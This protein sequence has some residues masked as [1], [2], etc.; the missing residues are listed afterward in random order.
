MDCHATLSTIVFPSPKSSSSN[1]FFHFVD[2]YFA[3]MTVMRNAWLISVFSIEV[4]VHRP[5][6]QFSMY[7]DSGSEQDGAVVGLS[8]DDRGFDPAS[9]MA[10]IRYISSFGACRKS[11][12]SLATSIPCRLLLAN[13]TVTE[14][15]STSLSWSV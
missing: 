15:T 12:S 6:A 9:N 10:L 14:S 13:S 7:C 4:K 5:K 2:S 1:R 3:H 11:V 8:S